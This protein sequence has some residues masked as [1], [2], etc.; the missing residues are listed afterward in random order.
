MALGLLFLSALI[1]GIAA[2]SLRYQYRTWD[3]LRTQT[4]ASDDRRYLRGVFQRRSI[5]AVL[6]FA[7]A[8]ML[9]SA[10]LFGGLDE[11]TRIAAMDPQDRTPEDRETVKSLAI[12]WMIVLGLLFFVLAIAMADYVAVTLYARDQLRRIR[13]EQHDLLE[14]DLAVYRQQKL[15]DRM[16]RRGK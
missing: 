12:Y 1:A 6:L 5:N 11:L 3:R 7:L 16:K 9:A 15:N 8:G 14:R 2:V 10:Y 13:H 4:L